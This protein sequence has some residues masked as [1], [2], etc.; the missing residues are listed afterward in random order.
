MTKRE[1][2][3]N[4]VLFCPINRDQK[5]CGQSLS[6]NNKYHSLVI[7]DV[8]VFRADIPPNK[9]VVFHSRMEKGA[10]LRELQYQHLHLCYWETDYYKQVLKRFLKDIDPKGRVAAD[11]G[12][13]DGRFTELLLEIGFDKVVA[14]DVDVRPLHELA[15]YAEEKGFREKLLLIQGSADQRLLKDESIDVAL[16]IGVLYY[17]NERFENGL[18]C[19]TRYLKPGGILIDSEPDIEGAML[20]A[21]FFESLSE[22]IKIYD[23]HTFTESHMGEKFRFRLFSRDEIAAYYE[24]ADL[25]TVDQHPL[26]IFPSILRISMVR[27][28]FSVEE[29]AALESEIRK[30]FDYVNRNGR[31]AKHIIWKTEKKWP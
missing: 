23:E 8:G 28:R 6:A 25:Q 18:Q 11:I 21:L 22:Y 7:D 2:W 29:V 24:K 10:A 30:T 27:E 9:D 16:T 31:I 5:K 1:D 4:S 15:R 3:R 13:G 19:V 17:L 26:S 12:C 20:K 14:V